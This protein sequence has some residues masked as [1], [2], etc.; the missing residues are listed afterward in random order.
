MR[1]ILAIALIGLATPAAAAPVPFIGCRSDGQQGPQ[2]APSGRPRDVPGPEAARLADYVMADGTRTLAPRGWLC[3]GL[4]GSDGSVLF[5]AP[6][7]ATLR[8]LVAGQQVRG[9]AV[10]RR[11]SFGGTSGRFAVARMAAM[12]FPAASRFV[13]DVEAEKIDGPFP[14]GLPRG[15]RIKR[16][17]PLAAL[18]TTPANGQ[19]VGTRAGFAPSPLPVDGSAVMAA[20]DDHDLDTVDARLSPAMR[21]LVAGIIADFRRAHGAAVPASRR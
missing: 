16:I 3:S 12:L 13:S 8:S 19:G 5:V 18:Y 2:A 1:Q 14:R 7:A 20:D 10:V 9:A 17:G 11:T 21:P 4:S 6:D 15:D